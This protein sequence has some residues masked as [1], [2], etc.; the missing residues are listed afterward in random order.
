LFR[1]VQELINNTIKHSNATQVIVTLSEF[2]DFISLYYFDNGGGFDLK[3]IKFGSGI[4]N[5]KERVEIF[6][7]K[8][9]INANNGS[10]IFV[11][12]LPI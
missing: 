10:A 12:E 8:I 7:G 2:D 4:T 6:N 1:I 9:E 5:I 11:I 3:T